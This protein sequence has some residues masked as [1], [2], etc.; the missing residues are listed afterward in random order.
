MT[1]WVGMNRTIIEINISTMKGKFWYTALVAAMVCG[2]VFIAGA[3]SSDPDNDSKSTLPRFSGIMFTPSTLTAG[4]T[5]TATAVQ[6]KKGKLLDRTQYSWSFSSEEGSLNSDKRGVFYTNDNAD[7]TC[8]VT[9][10]TTPGTYTLTFT[11][12]YNVSGHADNAT[13]SQDIEGGQVVYTTSPLTCSVVI[14]RKV[15]VK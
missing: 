14:T 1:E 9:L 4:T 3:C 2:L 11:G 12:V 10:P 5:V 7:P 13:E 15:Q 8:R 6:A